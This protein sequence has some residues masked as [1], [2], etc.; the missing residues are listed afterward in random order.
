MA[1]SARLHIGLDALEP[2][3]P[4]PNAAHTHPPFRG[5]SHASSSSHPMSMTADNQAY[6]RESRL[7]LLCF[8]LMP[9]ISV[10]IHAGQPSFTGIFESG[11]GRVL[12]LA[13]SLVHFI[14]KSDSAGIM[15]IDEYRRQLRMRRLN[16]RD[17]M[18]IAAVTHDHDRHDMAQDVS[19][20]QQQL[21]HRFGPDLGIGISQLQPE[22]TRMQLLLRQMD[23]AGTDIFE[24]REA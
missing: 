23:R 14:G 13:E 15:I 22:R 3:H 9:S 8:P 16:L 5:R 2:I 19:D 24:R 4:L 20:A 18:N 11:P 6:K 1:S 21:L 17:D 12:D 10:P 7:R